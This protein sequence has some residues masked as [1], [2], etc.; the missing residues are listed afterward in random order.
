MQNK[1]KRIMWLINHNTLRPFEVPMLLSFG[2]EVYVS[3]IFDCTPENFSASIT[4]EYDSSLTI[5]ISDL[6][7]L[8]NHNFYSTEISAQIKSIINRYFGTMIIAAYPFMLQEAVLNFKGRIILRAF[9][10]PGEKNKYFEYFESVCGPTITNTLFKIQDR[11]WLGYGY[12]GIEK[13]ENSFM[14]KHSAFL[15]L[16]LPKSITDKTG[17]W[18]GEKMLL[19]FVCPRIIPHNEILYKNFKRDFRDFPHVIAGAQTVKIDDPTI[20]DRVS[21]EELDNLLTSC[22]VMYYHSRELRHIHYHPIEAIIFGMP[23]IFMKGGLLDSLSAGFH[24]PGAC[25]TISEAKDKIKKILSGDK[26]FISSIKTAQNV[27][28]KVFSEKFCRN[29]WND[30]FI[31][32]IL[33]NKIKSESPLKIVIFY[34]EDRA[35]LF[36][37]LN[38]AKNLAK[39]IHL[40]SR[41]HGE[42]VQVIFSCKPNIFKNEANL[43]DLIDLGIEIRE[44]DWSIMT[45]QEYGYVENYNSN[46]KKQNKLQSYFLP[47]DGISNFNDCDKWLLFSDLMD[48]PLAPVQKYGIFFNGIQSSTNMQTKSILNENLRNSQYIL[49]NS[50]FLQK[51]ISYEAGIKID[52]IFVTP[53]FINNNKK[54]FFEQNEDNKYFILRIS[55]DF[56]ENMKIVLKALLTYYKN[57]SGKLNCIIIGDDFG[58]TYSNCLAISE[59]MEEL[60]A[61]VSE[62]NLSIKLLKNELESIY[63]SYVS[64]ACFSCHIISEEHSII[65]IL[66]TASLGIP[67]LSNKHDEIRHADEKMQLNLNYVNV[68]SYLNIAQEL[69]NMEDNFF[70]DKDRISVQ[71]RFDELHYENCADSFWKI[72]RDII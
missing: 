13:H 33:K 24:Q 5:P 12:A 25:N 19:L 9:G 39:V 36:N 34:I 18:T 69:K 41:Y 8:N 60:I 63:M 31:N 17:T 58:E 57:F 42:P 44:T 6:E 4:Y 11:F 50:H 27:I 38:I 72:C 68:T 16:G 7:I 54:L 52:K 37:K 47:K 35:H 48:Y 23:L 28:L 46:V 2:L 15:P 59:S 21:R 70:G 10:L 1:D 56:I 67:I 55:F 61:C 62:L 20:I 65:E 14:Q 29:A 32:G 51:K 30:N 49:T 26:D 22:A 40:G 66:E 71:K 45:S 43:V 3:K 53:L 64:H